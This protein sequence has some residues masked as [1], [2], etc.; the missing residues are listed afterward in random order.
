MVCAVCRSCALQPTVLA[1]F[2]GV[3]VC[4]CV[5]LKVSTRAA[6]AIKVGKKEY[7]QTSRRKGH[8]VKMNTTEENRPQADPQLYRLHSTH[9]ATLQNR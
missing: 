6:S 4:R 3:A 9:H 2:T 5:A 7:M 1:S 8:A